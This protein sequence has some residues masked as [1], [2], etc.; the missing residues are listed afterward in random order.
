[1]IDASGTPY[2]DRFFGTNDNRD[3]QA[4]IA[5]RPLRFT[6]GGKP[7]VLNTPIIQHSAEINPRSHDL[8]GILGRD[9]LSEADVVDFDFDAMTLTLRS[10]PT[11]PPRRRAKRTEN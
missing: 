2:T 11:Q 7:V 4:V 3:V 6:I 10:S 1:V 8:E 5:R 9:L